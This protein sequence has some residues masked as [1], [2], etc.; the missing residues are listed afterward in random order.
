M[1]NKSLHSSTDRVEN[2]SGTARIKLM[3]RRAACTESKEAAATAASFATKL[4]NKTNERTN[5][6]TTT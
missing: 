4:R 6:R 5:E 2:H 3:T 1:P